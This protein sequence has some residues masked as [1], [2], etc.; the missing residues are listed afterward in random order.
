MD[1]P[2]KKSK[3]ILPK[4]FRVF[5]L[6]IFVTLAV[7]FGY[8]QI[9]G[10]IVPTTITL[11][12]GSVDAQ[13]DSAFG[14]LV[15]NLMQARSLYVD[16]FNLEA[17]VNGHTLAM[18]GDLAFVTETKSIYIDLDLVYDDRVFDVG[19]V[20][21]SPNL[22]L[23][24]ED[25]AY[26][27]EVEQAASGDFDVSA[28]MGIVRN[29]LPFDMSVLTDKLAELGIDLDNPAA[30]MEKLEITEKEQENG[31]FDFRVGLGNIISVQI[32]TDENY[33]IQSVRMRDVQINKTGFKAKLRFSAPHITMNNEDIATLIVAPEE[34]VDLTGVSA[35][36]NYAKNLVE[37]DIIKVDA[38]VEAFGKAYDATITIDKTDDLK[39]KAETE[40]CGVDVSI[41]YADEIIYLDVENLKFK[42]AIADYKTWA[43]AISNIIENHTSKTIA[44]V[45]DE[46]IERF[47]PEDVRNFDYENVDFEKEGK[48]LL[49]RL[50]SG[51][52]EIAMLLPD[53]AVEEENKMTISWANGLTIVLENENELLSM[54]AAEYQ[55]N[56]ISAEISVAQDGVYVEGDYYD[57]TNLAPILSFADEVL[58]AKGL[59]GVARVDYQGYSVSVQFGADFE[60]ELVFKALIENEFKN[61]EVYVTMQSAYLVLDEI[62]LE[63]NFDCIEDYKS[64]IE[65][66]FGIQL[67]E[68]EMSIDMAG[69]L[70]S[71]MAVLKDLRLQSLD[72][73]VTAIEYLTHTATI[74]VQDD[75]LLLNYQNGDIAASVE[76]SCGCE[77]IVVPAATDTLSSLLAKAANLK[78]YIEGGVYAA[79]FNID[80]GEQNV[81]GNIQIDI[82]NKVMALTAIYDGHVLTANYQDETIYLALDGNKIRASVLQAKDLYEL[83]EQVLADNAIEIPEIDIAEY[84]PE[85]D[86][87]VFDILDDI[88][89]SLLGNLNNLNLL[90]SYKADDIYA[91]VKF[92][93]NN[94]K[95]VSV[96]VRD[97]DATFNI[98]TYGVGSVDANEYYD[99][100]SAQRG[101]ARLTINGIEQL[102]NVEFD[103]NAPYFK[104][105]TTLLDEDVS[106]VILKDKAYLY[107][108]ELVLCATREEIISLV[109]ELLAGR[110]FV[111]PEIEVGN[112]DIDD[113]LNNRNYSIRGSLLKVELENVYVELSPCAP[114]AFVEPIEYISVDEIKNRIG[115]IK[116]A[117][118]EKSVEFDIEFGYAGY[119]AEAKVKFDGETL[120]IT[121]ELENRELKAVLKD[122]TIYISYANVKLK[123]NFDD[124]ELPE[125]DVEKLKEKFGDK[126]DLDIE[127]IERIKELAN[128]FKNYT[129]QDVLNNVKLSLTGD[130]DNIGLNVATDEE[131]LNARVAFANDKL[132]QIELLI[133]DEVSIKLSNISFETEIA[134]LGEGHYDLDN[135][136]PAM[137]IAKE[138]LDKK[139][140]SGVVKTEFEGR[141]I[142]LD[143]VLDFADGIKAKLSTTLFGETITIYVNGSEITLQIGEVLAKGNVDDVENYL[144]RIDQIFGTTFEGLTDGMFDVSFDQDVNETIQK[145]LSVLD[146]IE[147]YSTDE[148]NLVVEYDGHTTKISF[149]NGAVKVNYSKDFEVLL[150]A[151]PTEEEIIIPETDE[152][153]DTLLEKVKNLKD[154]V[155]GK[156]YAVEFELAYET[157]TLS[158]MLQADFEAEIFAIE[159][160]YNGKFVKLR[161]E[162]GMAYVEDEPNKVQLKIDNV[163]SVIGIVLP[164]LEANGIDLSLDIDV[165][166]ILQNIFGE[167][168]L[169]LT[170]EDVLDR[171]SMDLDGSFAD[172]NLTAALSGN[173]LM[174]A[175]VGIKFV[176]DDLKQ[177]QLSVA[178]VQARITIDELVFAPIDAN[179]YYDILSAQRGYARLTINGIEQLV[180]VEFDLNAPYFKASTTLLDED[181]SIVIL[182]DKAYLYVGELVL[183][184]TREEIISL[185]KE[186]LA[187]REF[188]LPEIEFGNIGINDI[189]NNRNYSIR[190]DLLK[191]E[192]E[193]VYV[194]LS[195]CAQ[196]AFV[197]P[198]EYISVDEIKNRIGEIKKVL[199]E[200]TVEFDVEFG[201]AGYEAEAKVK[202]DGETLEITTELENRELKAVLKDNTIYISYANVKLKYNFDDTELPE[203]DVEELKEKFGDKFD[204]D[205]EIIERIKELVK[206][207]KNYTIQDVLNNVKF[208]LTGDEN[209]IGLNV[210]TDE[211][212]LNARVAFAGDKLS[213]IEILL[214]GEISIKL[215]NIAFET[216]IAELGEGYYDLDNIMPAM[217]IVQEILDKKQI[218][219]VVKAEF[220][221]REIELDYVLD[222][223]DG[224]KAKLSTTLFGETI[225]IYVNG[226]EI[227][228]QI[229]EILAK[230]NVDDVE[231]YLARI[232]QIFGTTFEGLTDGMFDVSFDQDVNE[233]IQ[234]VL[235]VLDEIE[236]YS[237]DEFNLVAKYDGHTAKISFV[238]GAVKVNYS[239]DFEVLLTAVPTEEEIIIP[240]TD[241]SADTLLEKVKNLKD[242]VEGK[243][244]AIEFELTYETLTLS[245]ILQADFEAEIFA[246]ELTY[247]GKFVKLRYEDG[248]AYVEDESNKVQL[249]ID[250]VKSVIGIVLPILEANGID[251]NLD[252]DVEE[253]LQNIFGENVLELTLEEV[254]DRL[255]MDLD[256]S[257]ADLNLTAALS[258]NDL[259][260]AN[261]GIKFVNDDLKQIQLSVAG[262]QARIT[263]DELVFAPID[264]NEYYNFLSAQ[265]GSLKVKVG[266][267]EIDAEIKLDL[268]GDIFVKAN[269]TLLGENLEI[270]IDNNMLY[271][272]FG[273][274]A[275][276][277]DFD[278]A[279]EIADAFADVF[280]FVLPE[281]SSDFDVEIIKDLDINSILA[282]VTFNV[283]GDSFAVAYKDITLTLTS[284]ANFTHDVPQ[285]YGSVENLVDKIKNV[286]KLVDDKLVEAQ[287]NVDYNGFEF[288]GSIK[289]GNGV[290]EIAVD[291]VGTNVVVRLENEKLYFTYGNMKCMF[292]VS[293]TKTA[294][295]GLME[296]LHKITDESFPV[297]IN[298]GV[299]EEVVEM[300]LD[301]DIDDWLE[302]LL[303]DVNGN[304]DDI[305]LTIS[306]KRDILDLFL[307]SVEVKFAQDRLSE[308]DL[309]VF[310]LLSAN[311]Q[312]LDVTESTIS[313]FNAAEYEE[314]ST[315]FTKGLLDSLKVREDIYAFSGD[316]DVRYSNNA[317]HGKLT[318]M[319]KYDEN[320][321]TI[322][323]H[324]VPALQIYTDALGLET[325]IY[326]VDQTIYIDIHGLQIYADLSTTTIEEVLEFVDDYFGMSVDLENTSVSSLATFRYILPAI[327]KI[328][329]SWLNV[330]ENNVSFNGVQIAFNDDFW[331]GTASKFEKTIL[332]VFV[333]NQNNTIL[334][335][336]IMIGANIID[337]N[338]IVY[339][340]YADYWMDVETNET[341]NLNFA[342]YLTNISVGSGVTA[343]GDVFVQSGNDVVALQS[344]YGATNLEEFNSYSTLLDMAK[345]VLDL[346][347]DMKYQLS[348]D[349]TMSGASTTKLGANINVEIGDLAENEINNSGFELFNGKYL[350]VQGAISLKNTIEHLLNVYYESKD[351]SAIYATYT[352]GDFIGSGSTIKQRIANSSNSFKAK[353]RNSS[354]SEIFSMVAKFANINFGDDMKESLGLV[355]CNTDFTYLQKLLGMERNEEPTTI[356]QGDKIIGTIEDVTKMLKN[357]KLTSVGNT[358]TLEISAELNDVTAKLSII[359]KTESGTMKLRQIKV[360]NLAFG[361][362]TINATINIE[363]FNANNFDYNKNAAHIDV[364]DISSFIDVAVS[365]INTKNWQFKGSTTVSLGGGLYTIGVGF[366]VY[367]GLDENNKLYMYIE[368]DVEFKASVTGQ[369][370][371]NPEYT[372][373]IVGGSYD[374][375]TSIIEYKNDYLTIV[376]HTYGVKTTAFSSKED[377]H[378]GYG[379][380]DNWRYSKD[381]IA[382]N[383]MV[384]MAEAL[385]LSEAAYDIIKTAI[386]SVEAHPTIEE[387]FLGF[388]KTSSG[389]AV[390]INAENLTGMNGVENM[391]LN[392]GTSAPYRVRID[393]VDQGEHRFINSIST[394]MKIGS[395]VSIPLTLN[396]VNGTSYRTT[397]GKTLYTNDHYRKAYAYQIKTLSFE[398][399]CSQYVAPI[400]NP[401]AEAITIPSLSNF[402]TDDG[403]TYK[404]YTFDGWWT[405]SDFRA[406]TRYESNLMPNDNTTLYAKWIVDTKHYRSV[407]FVTNSSQSVSAIYDIEGT[408]FS[409]PTLE[410]YIVD[411]G[412][413]K[414]HYSFDGW[415]DNAGLSGNVLT[416]G[417]VQPQNSSIYAAWAVE[418][419]YYRTITFVTNYEESV[420]SITALVGT[421]ITISALEKQK[422]E[423][424][425]NITT[426]YSFDGWWTTSNFVANTR[427]TATKMPEQD[428]TLYAKWDV[429]RVERSYQITLYDN[430]VAVDSMR[431]IAGETFSLVGLNKVNSTTRFYSDA[432]YTSQITNFVMPE[433]DLNIHI[434]NQYTLTYSY[435]AKENN[436]Y[437]K[438]TATKTLYQGDSFGLPTQTN[439]SIDYKNSSNE[440]SY[441]KYFTFGPYSNV[442]DGINVMP[443]YDYTISNT[444]STSTKNYYKII[445]DVRTYA[446]LG[447]GT[448][449]WKVLPTA[450]A[451]EYHFAGDVI[452][453]NQSKYQV[454]GE[455]Y[456][457]AFKSGTYKYKATTW[458][459]SA[460][461]S[462]TAGGS[463]F[464]SYTVAVSDA[465]SDNYSIR[466]YACWERY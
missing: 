364:S 30:L 4:M 391:T 164:I 359:F 410:N 355:E 1:N 83:I 425:G 459:L 17:D 88:R 38:S 378:R 23:S 396:S 149:V 461:G 382:P 146:E 291:I 259:M 74:V 293:N 55:G 79:A 446:V 132:A 309:Q 300:L 147:I 384:I 287:F 213:Q 347:D 113:I 178:G 209:D 110:E 184:A 117:L 160:T 205:I 99:I 429:V 263:I 450:P 246:I 283:S 317:F 16:D 451:P 366:D 448:D 133:L 22:Y 179:E 114:I 121:T 71:S 208:Y 52:N 182:K 85:M 452:N 260:N 35:Y 360:E 411:N 312:I 122:D 63:I 310:D 103:L 214:L 466:L 420:D 129:I 177:I 318:A 131:L 261:V 273:E 271:I 24:V 51:S 112:I 388:S 404:T 96:Q 228:L 392:L 330:I 7:F 43:G 215:S 296:F 302:N 202:F 145:V 232:D 385:G 324:Y 406:G 233:T 152:S 433:Q 335:R 311:I 245:G 422:Q 244:Y 165:E 116:R 151:V 465:G 124:T 282:D 227:T 230:G 97:V 120:E 409:L 48:N 226:S 67:P 361:G 412:V 264:A 197:G 329:G 222:F 92:T 289:Y 13:E 166:E 49:S 342:G 150:T 216:E 66:I 27:I 315:D 275:L 56:K 73:A 221:G 250:N 237:T 84:L 137:D 123:Y 394:E 69:A 372:V 39:V 365:T 270:V 306:K 256:G 175:N 427:F 424:I 102:V 53:N 375:R 115:E 142:E 243:K 70:S 109:K 288:V 457:T 241:E 380:G 251:L 416:S 358:T 188:A 374:R 28:V 107:V 136:M 386:N 11:P 414:T 18:Q 236:I 174:D 323:G 5:T 284:G 239:K 348:V 332:Q 34:Y 26:L 307:A 399:N 20:Y 400:V 418:V 193:N 431:A 460:W 42:F 195:P 138:I 449:A 240:E 248:M 353:I 203:V 398:T 272:T 141:E 440:L 134:E 170:M 19:A 436:D 280:G 320:A 257:F 68:I 224:I 367:A 94:L 128:E 155:E 434:R 266:D 225:T 15:E 37:K 59:N 295:M 297:E 235:S 463:G 130:E 439:D 44:E 362:N 181:V 438:K 3:R 12:S 201:Y 199:E 405:T 156:K 54:V 343:L 371:P 390:T 426:F 357:L 217:D 376:Q 31:D 247:N 268:S 377:K 423:T 356:A 327:D 190:A 127:I 194:E 269:T 64:Q 265:E 408:T 154:Y 119:E 169:E 325:Y 441:R 253:I 462:L 458:G 383:M 350:K 393:G 2:I 442:A 319:L 111:L 345:A 8:V 60:N 218:S 9:F 444:I 432:G 105:S 445:F 139:Q 464:K 363:D 379:Y 344:N 101:Y 229:G 368:L 210:A 278:D 303:L 456:K 163:K 290:L 6:Y 305:S 262:I 281:I 72:D 387:A 354:L 223:A 419:E 417:V 21:T 157:L 328:Y 62:V 340:S 285:T 301:Y 204:L 135:I 76:L 81:Y 61:I 32:L 176:N 87:S 336:K 98:L 212:L 211:E 183:C 207:F 403:I 274:L 162:D 299:F 435:Y 29:Y 277:A 14:E 231:N 100:L 370:L 10:G 148:F 206:E 192:L 338:T 331:Y 430:G 78:S 171:L 337:P 341:K 238:N 91:N 106:I 334:P 168:V 333:D 75:V 443:N 219:G 173:D 186:L 402:V 373:Y 161:Y 276:G 455:G 189:L 339:D 369:A 294:S 25:E 304:V 58:L 89:I 143:Y 258:G 352:H 65:S 41:V 200:K 351:S 90:V 180:N 249:K 45:V 321:N 86:V 144:A 220:E 57:L 428:T 421:P 413:T 196:I 82:N 50:L 349:G 187:G 125:V 198:I 126:F 389:Y 255:S 313:T 415:F 407:N 453:L 153:V 140:I 401:A 172:L 167:N 77:E 104:A 95:S 47:V 33:N 80:K 308:I 314:Y 185:A 326:I 447:M 108:G 286:K 40:V 191:V 118:E 395:F 242:Y 158:G 93:N 46:L 159:L 397:G 454:T 316:I 298:F 279:K 252:I 234:K 292:D 381:Q 322:L 437:V 267:Y 36:V 254:L 346:A